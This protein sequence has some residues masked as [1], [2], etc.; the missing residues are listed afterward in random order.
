MPSTKKNRHGGSSANVA[1]DVCQTEGHNITYFNLQN[2][3]RS[4]FR[5]TKCGLSLDEIRTGEIDQ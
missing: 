5:C 1:G 2:E 4:E 3:S